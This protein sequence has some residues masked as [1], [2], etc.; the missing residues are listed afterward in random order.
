MSTYYFFVME[1]FCDQ[2]YEVVQLIPRG[3]VSTYKEVAAALDSK[4]YRAVGGALRNNP[5]APVVPCHRVVKSDRSLGGF[6]GEVSGKKIVEKKALLLS[7]GVLFDD[8]KICSESLFF[9]TQ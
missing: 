4:A 5:F 2:V 8:E 9:F 1:R 7:E 6:G 3:K